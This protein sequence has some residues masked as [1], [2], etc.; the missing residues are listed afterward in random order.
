MSSKETKYYN[1]G[2]IHRLVWCAH[3]YLLVWEGGEVGHIS[4]EGQ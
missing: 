4:I 2:I 1:L 3:V